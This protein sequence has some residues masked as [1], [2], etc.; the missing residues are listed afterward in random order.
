M[1][2]LWFHPQ[3]I[4]LSRLFNFYSLLITYSNILA[5]DWFRLSTEDGCSSE[6]VISGDCWCSFSSSTGGKFPRLTLC[7]CCIEFRDIL[8]MLYMFIFPTFT[9]ESIDFGSRYIYK[10]CEQPFCESCCDS[11]LLRYCCSSCFS[12]LIRRSI[13]GWFSQ[14]C[15]WF[16]GCPPSWFLGEGFTRELTLVLSFLAGALMSIVSSSFSSSSSIWEIINFVFWFR[17]KALW[18]IVP[19]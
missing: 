18:V 10:F 8:C 2:N 15:W 11:I 17:S 9:G 12:L 1:V 6:P 19:V 16:S 5:A 3:L 14:N 7:F 13:E 4:L